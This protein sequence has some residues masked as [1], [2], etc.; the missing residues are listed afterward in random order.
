MLEPITD[1]SNAR[2][3]VTNDDGYYAEGIR[4]LERIALALSEDVWVVAPATEQSATSH[5]LTLR[6]PLR[7]EQKQERHFTVDGTPTDC[8]LVA[9]HHLL[10]DH[11]PDLVL[12]GINLGANMAEDVLYSGTVAAAMEGATVGLRSIAMSQLRLPDGS[13]DF[14]GAET[15][16]PGIVRALCALTWRRETLMNVN[17]PAVSA[18]AMGAVKVVRLGRRESG[19]TIVEGRDPGGRPYIWIGQYLTDETGSADSDLSTV[20]EG[21]IA[22]TPLYLDMTDKVGMASV[23]EMIGE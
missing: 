21:D 2:I 15:R 16:G 3:L 11:Q 22:V 14:S 13:L 17:F 12:S 7:V 20:A 19:T 8:V 9:C 4:A 23:A 18:E 5:S 1:L 10:K 6:R